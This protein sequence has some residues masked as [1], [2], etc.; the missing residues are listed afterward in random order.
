MIS[1]VGTNVVSEIYLKKRKK[2]VKKGKATN[3]QISKGPSQRK[4]VNVVRQISIVLSPLPQDPLPTNLV[5]WW[6][7]V[8]G[9]HPL[10]CTTLFSRGHVWSHDKFGQKACKGRN[11]V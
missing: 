9:F 1:M 3:K 11:L 10:S 2:K 7:R 4:Q 8:M 5:E 6:L